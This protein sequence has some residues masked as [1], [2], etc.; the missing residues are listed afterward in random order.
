MVGEALMIADQLRR[1]LKYTPLYPM[2]MGGFAPAIRSQRDTGCGGRRGSVR[3]LSLIPTNSQWKKLLA[4][5][6]R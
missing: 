2:Q 4:K 3:H 5:R 6:E 1:K